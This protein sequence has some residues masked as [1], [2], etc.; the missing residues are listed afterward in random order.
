MPTRSATCPVLSGLASKRSASSICRSAFVRL[1]RTPSSRASAEDRTKR[2]DPLL[3]GVDRIGQATPHVDRSP[4][5]LRSA[6]LVHGDQPGVGEPAQVVR[7][8]HNAT[9]SR[10]AS[11]SARI[12]SATASWPCRAVIAVVGW[13]AARTARSAI[14]VSTRRAV[15]RFSRRHRDM[16]SRRVGRRPAG[17]PLL[18]QGL[19]GCIGVRPLQSGRL[20][21]FM[22]GGLGVLQK[23]EIAPCLG[24]VEAE[25]DQTFDHVRQVQETSLSAS[26]GAAPGAGKYIYSLNMN[27]EAQ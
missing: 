13:G 23:S 17:E 26:C 6:R 16:A 12:R 19:Q 27:I 4:H 2:T 18:A 5:R 3:W 10:A 11:I 25:F 14:R 22:P 15:C 20:G 7:Q 21:E 24:L 8:Q 9:R 1:A